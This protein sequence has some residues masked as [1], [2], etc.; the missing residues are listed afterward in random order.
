MG[1]TLQRLDGGLDIRDGLGRT[2][3]NEVSP[4]CG[5]QGRGSRVTS[6]ARESA[7]PRTAASPAH[8]CERKSAFRELGSLARECLP[9]HRKRAGLAAEARPIAGSPRAPRGSTQRKGSTSHIA[10]R[11][12]HYASNNYTATCSARGATWC[13]CGRSAVRGCAYTSCLLLTR[14][15]GHHS[16]AGAST[17]V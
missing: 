4:V 15:L 3:L 5:A 17:R 11:S 6:R 12:R 14:W 7:P 2:H 16:P 1:L 13:V 9:C 8:L 10:P